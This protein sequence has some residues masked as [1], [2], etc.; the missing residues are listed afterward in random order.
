MKRTL[1][2]FLCVVFCS[3]HA[4]TP[5]MKQL[6]AKISATK[7]DSLRFYLAFSALTV[8]ETDPVEDMDNAEIIVLQG[9]KTK[10]P[11]CLVM[12]YGCLGYDYRAFG[13]TAKSLEYDLKANK[14]AEQSHSERL[15]MLSKILL[16]MNYL[17]LKD[18]SKAVSYNL[19]AL[20]HASKVEVNLFTIVAN[21]NMGEIYLAMNKIDLALRYTQKAFEL[22]TSS[23]IKDYLGAIYGQLGTIQSRLHNPTLARSYVELSLK[24][25]RKI[26][27]PKYINIAYG[28][29]ADQ[30]MSSGETDSAMVYSKKAIGAVNGTPFSTMKMKPAKLLL[31]I[32]RTRNID[33]AFKY[34]EM[35]KA[36][37]DSLYNIKALQQAET[38]DL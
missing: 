19:T 7:N 36:A 12:G 33:S 14:I 30:F 18:Y 26:N 8:S 10:D 31:D 21:L 25:A 22:T 3:M 4:Q 16:A 27:S 2:F 1:L 13:N 9:Q 32:Y 23:G 6:L 29:I 24:E 20:R 37:N 15:M 34:S 5:N 38:D 11:V 35:N 17:D 28:S